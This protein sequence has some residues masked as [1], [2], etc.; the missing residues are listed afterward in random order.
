VIDLFSSFPIDQVFGSEGGT[1]LRLNKLIRLLRMVK[2][3]RLFRLYRLS[4]GSE[5]AHFIDYFSPSTIRLVAVF[6]V[7]VTWF[8][9]LACMY[10]MLV[11]IEWLFLESD[12]QKAEVL[13]S[14]WFPPPYVINDVGL[15]ADDV[16][17]TWIDLVDSNVVAMYD[18]TLKRTKRITTAYLWSFFW[19][20]SLSTGY[21]DF[22]PV[23]QV[24]TLLSTFVVLIGF[25][26]SAIIL[27]SMTTALSEMNAVNARHKQRLNEIQQYLKV[28]DVPQRVRRSVAA[29]YNF[30]GFNA[31]DMLIDLP[32][33][34]RLQIDIV[35]N[36]ALFLKVPAFRECTLVQIC[37]LVPR[38]VRQYAL[39]GQHIMQEGQPASGL[40]MIARGI[41]QMLHD[42][43]VIGQ[44][45]KNDFFGEKSVLVEGGGTGAEYT[46]QAMELVELMVLHRKELNEVIS[47]FP[48]L[49][50][51]LHK[52][53][54][55]RDEKQR[56]VISQMMRSPSV[57]NFWKRALASNN[58]DTR[59]SKV[60]PDTNVEVPPEALS[61]VTDWH[62]YRRA[63]QAGWVRESR[64]ERSALHRLFEARTRS[65]FVPVAIF[66]WLERA[67]YRI[68]QRAIAK[69]QM[70][71]RKQTFFKK[72]SKERELK[73]LGSSVR[74]L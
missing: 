52:E 63:C 7:M 9:F 35:T 32:T 64:V 12:A 54:T 1:A 49:R 38:I 6:I 67:R 26:A 74:I 45:G 28:K 50:I 30:A 68:S 44:L 61:L 66:H 46:V 60:A 13:G 22:V 17:A 57:V 65:N 3:L 33:N 2:L 62:A 58:T 23:S 27:G 15:L 29:F 19:A 4:Q 5:F 20:A 36:R 55:K 51:I 37:E 56:E 43:T 69:K 40:F 47:L 71:K 24:Q 21:Q 59:G 16:N 70:G 10:W 31:D 39:R 18:L 73:K 41:C 8:H 48:E 53:A 42:K 34:L 11:E 14:D 25:V 72:N